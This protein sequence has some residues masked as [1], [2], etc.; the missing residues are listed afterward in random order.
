MPF[1]CSG[2]PNLRKETES[3]C[4]VHKCANI[5]HQKVILPWRWNHANSFPNSH[6][7]TGGLG[8]LLCLEWFR[9]PEAVIRYVD[10][11]LSYSRYTATDLVRGVLKCLWSQTLMVHLAPVRWYSSMHAGTVWVSTCMEA[12]GSRACI[13]VLQQAPHIRVASWLYAERC[14]AGGLQL[15]QNSLKAK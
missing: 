2:L 13:Q 5:I 12:M 3:V 7:Y 9:L 15:D 10:I 4:E 8:I 14:K 11:M 1:L 6:N